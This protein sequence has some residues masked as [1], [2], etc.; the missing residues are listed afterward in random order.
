MVIHACNPSVRKLRQKDLWGLLARQHNL[1]GT[2]GYL[3]QNLVTA[4]LEKQHPQLVSPRTA[5]I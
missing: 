3:S 2:M 5:Q 4:V 1:I